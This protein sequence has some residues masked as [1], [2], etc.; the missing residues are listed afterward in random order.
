MVV[1]AFLLLRA[2]RLLPS[3]PPP[4]FFFSTNGDDTGSL[5]IGEVSWL[6]QQQPKGREEEEDTWE[7][8]ID[9]LLAVG[10]QLAGDFWRPGDVCSLIR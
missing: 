2:L 3:P 1:V 6:F 10:V 4:P 9:R 8:L 5:F 7:E